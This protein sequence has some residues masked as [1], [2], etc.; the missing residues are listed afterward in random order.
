MSILVLSCIGGLVSAVSTG[1]GAVFV[2][3]LMQFKTLGKHHTS[4][5]FALGVMLSASIFSLIGPQLLEGKELNLVYSGLI[6]G[7]LFILLTH[8]IIE[9][10]NRDQKFNPYQ[11]LLVAALIFHN[12]PE[13]MGA[14]ASLAGLKMIDAIPVQIALSIQ[15]LVEGFI[16]TILLRA[17]GLSL[18][19]AVFLGIVSGLVEMSGA[20][21]AGVILENTISALP[22]FL[23]FAGASMMMSVFM[24]FHEAHHA[25]REI[26]KLHIFFGLLTIPIMSLFF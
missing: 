18:P 14:G 12:L 19:W 6:S 9:Y 22:Y 25:K 8:R 10:F 3:I 23:A 24:E 7:F 20:V 15:N 13:G 21:I 1:L 17:L 2:P 4:L 11:I 5:D 16:L 26:K